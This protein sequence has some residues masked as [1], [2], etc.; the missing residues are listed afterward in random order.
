MFES[1]TTVLGSATSLQSATAGTAYP[2]VYVSVGEL[3]IPQVIDVANQSGGLFSL[4]YAVAALFLMG[5]VLRKK[6]VNK[7]K[8]DETEEKTE[9]IEDKKPRN[10]RY[11]PKTKKA[12]E[13]MHHEDVFKPGRY[14]LTSK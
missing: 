4:L 6:P 2:N 3:Q 12:E 10:R 13:V 14:E 8:K 5:Y 9:T 1:I 7:D 11:T